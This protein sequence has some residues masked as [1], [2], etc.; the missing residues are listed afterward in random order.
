MRVGIIDLGTNSV[1]FDVHEL[2]PGR[3]LT[4]L[5]REKVMVRLGQ[6]VF[7]SGRLDRNAVRRTVHAFRHFRRVAAELHASRIV[8]FG[9]SALREA[10][11]RDRFLET[12]RRRS[13]IELRVISG[14]EEA[15]LIAQ[16][17]LGNLRPRGRVGL[18]DIGGGSTE[19]SIC[20][21]RE[22]RHAH[23]FRLGTARLAQVFLPHAP[24]RSGEL[25]ELRAFVRTTLEQRIETERWPRTARLL[26]SSGTV[27][28]VARL[29]RKRPGGQG[30]GRI[31]RPEL[32]RLNAELARLTPARLRELPGMEPK[33]VDM[34]L[35]GAVLLEECMTALGAREV[36]PVDF[37]LRDGILLEELARLRSGSRSQLA[38]H[39]PDLV[40]AARRFG[41]S[42][43]HVLALARLAEGLFDS[44]R[45]VHRLRPEFRAPLAAAALLKNTGD[46][47]SPLNAEL[48]SHYIVRHLSFPVCEPWEQSLVAELCRGVR[49]AKL[50]AKSNPF[51]ARRRLAEAYERLLPL[52]QVVDALD[53]GRES[54]PELRSVKILRTRVALRLGGKG[55]SGL[56]PMQLEL[57]QALF[58]RVYGRSV[59]VELARS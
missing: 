46:A 31:R 17:V 55:L 26:G 15:R 4:R 2:V 25:E 35:A 59:A 40:P 38:L 34:I 50:P 48:H 57:R 10:E 49:F 52:L 11:D 54:R 47:I 42:D 32:A 1:R 20:A 12:V 9:T 45:F 21:A 18:I 43:R 24:P 13:G 3:P 7:L 58:S 37:S 28:A 51:R 33:R 29:L 36:E 27:R 53:T 8:A 22:V 19:I 23:S 5:H 41:A 14:E 39:L 6:G 44:L 56:E 16:A 30:D